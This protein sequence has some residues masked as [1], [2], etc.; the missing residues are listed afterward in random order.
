M[1][2]GKFWKQLVPER[3]HLT[4][5]VLSTTTSPSSSHLSLSIP[6]TTA[7]RINFSSSL[8]TT[9]T[10]QISVI[11]PQFDEARSQIHNSPSSSSSERVSFQF[12]SSPLPLPISFTT[13]PPEPV[14]KMDSAL[15]ADL[16]LK[17]FAFAGT[18]RDNVEQ[19]PKGIELAL[20]TDEKKNTWSD[21]LKV[22]FLFQNIKAGSPAERFVRRL[23]GETTGSYGKVCE[24]LKERFGNDDELAEERRRAEES[25]LELQQHRDNEH[26]VATQFVHRLDSHELRIH[27]MTSLGSHP[28]MNDTIIKVRHTASMLDDASPIAQQRESGFDHGTSSDDDDSESDD[29][30]SYHGKC[31]RRRRRERARQS[32]TTKGLKAQWE[33]EEA[34]NIRLEL[35]ELKKLIQKTQESSGNSPQPSSSSATRQLVQQT[36]PFV[37]TYAVNNLLA[38]PP[39]PMF[40]SMLLGQDRGQASSGVPFNYP[41]YRQLQLWNMNGNQPNAGYWH[42]LVGHWR[43]ECPLLAYPNSDATNLPSG[44]N[45]SSTLLNILQNTQRQLQPPQQPPPTANRGVTHN[46][47]STSEANGGLSRVVGTVAGIEIGSCSS[48]MDGMAVN[49]TAKGKKILAEN[50]FV[51]GLLQ[52]GATDSTNRNNVGDTMGG[53]RARPHSEVAESSGTAGEPVQQRLWHTYRQPGDD[54]KQWKLPKHQGRRPPIR[55]M[56]DQ[57]PFDFIG[58]LRDRLVTG[59]T[60]GHFF[61]L[62]PE[63]KRARLNGRVFELKY[64]LMDAG[65]VVNMSPISILQAIG[66]SL[67]RTWEITIRTATSILVEIEFYTDL[68]IEVASVT[69]CL[70]VYAI[71]A[72]CELNY[73]LLQSCR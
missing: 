49:I 12:P 42:V 52:E 38:P 11:W 55:L 46:Q 20:T 62:A 67:F 23:D 73:G 4:E 24:V 36:L 33:S 47:A 43:T 66:A 63:A 37:D 13:A 71:P 59:L 48:A 15:M 60:W 31:A 1:P 40:G 16:G 25:F 3:R 65:S 57:M 10:P 29:D 28:K 14:D 7:N 18:S 8:P 56:V 2:E 58:G 26:L 45:F 53:E 5:L 27:V 44:N 50:E 6:N 17:P 68:E 39:P 34:Q 70:R 72:I 51:K 32:K 64:I 41:P 21:E 19:F 9:P 69:T 22:Y 30:D 61:D 54:I 35:R